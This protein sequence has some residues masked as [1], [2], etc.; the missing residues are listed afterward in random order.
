M[1]KNSRNH[2]DRRSTLFMKNK[3]NLRD[4][5]AATGLV[6]LFKLDSNCWFFSP[7]E[8]EIW[9]MTS[10]NNRVPLLLYTKLCASFEIHGWIQTGVRVRKIQIRPWNSMDDF[11]KQQGTSSILHQALCIISKP[12]VN[13]KR[14]YS[15]ETLNSGQNRR[16]FCPVW[17]W[18][19]TDDLE[20]NRAHLLY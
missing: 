4:L 11:D 9:R 8:L 20:N 10:K 13:W 7:C 3:A 17:P 12:W 19:L 6:I 1:I 16:F 14:S 2:T 5:I 15:P 18:N